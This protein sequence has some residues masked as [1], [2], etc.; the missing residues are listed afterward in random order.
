MGRTA[1][2][3]KSI[4]VDGGN[5][6][7][8]TTSSEGEY[9]LVLT[10]NGYGKMSSIEEYRVMAHRGG[11]GVKTVKVSEKNGN[12]VCMKA[13]N[14]DEDLLVVTNKGVIIRVPLEQVKIASR[15]TQ[16]VRIIKL[17]DTSKVSSIEVAPKEEII[18]EELESTKE[19]NVQE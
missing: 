13:V 15:N 14:G 19:V 2:G 10:E 7:G 9:I 4:N 11:K 3:V 1:S 5:V 18:E 17:E 16:G 12:L 8:V 6:V